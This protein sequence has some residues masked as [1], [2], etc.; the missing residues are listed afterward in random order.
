[1]NK[2]NEYQDALERPTGML[3]RA[4]VAQDF[5][6]AEPMIR[7]YTDD[8]AGNGNHILTRPWRQECE[9]Q[10]RRLKHATEQLD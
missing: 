1:M 10:R 3:L 7:I 8:G 5:D 6:D 9:A 2:F 4:F